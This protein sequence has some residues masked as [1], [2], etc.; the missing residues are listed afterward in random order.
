MD[1]K[2]LN[3]LVRIVQK[4]AEENPRQDADGRCFFCDAELSWNGE[5]EGEHKSDCYWL[6][7]RQLRGLEQPVLDLKW[8][9]RTPDDDIP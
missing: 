9:V 1:T 3:V 5:E 2:M 7:A 6:A 4:V 8:Q